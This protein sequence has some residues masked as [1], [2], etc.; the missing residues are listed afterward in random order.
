M[1]EQCSVGSCETQE[2]RNTNA[3]VAHRPRGV[4]AFEAGIGCIAEEKL[5]L[6]TVSQNTRVCVDYQV[7]HTFVRRIKKARQARFSDN[8]AA[9]YH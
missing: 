8:G 3:P 9:S 5:D 6:N 2:V 1:S 4:F 7:L